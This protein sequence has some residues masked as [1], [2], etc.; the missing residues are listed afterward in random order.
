MTY[1]W[2]Y[3]MDVVGTPTMK[4]SKNYT[5]RDSEKRQSIF[6]LLLTLLIICLFKIIRTKLLKND[7]D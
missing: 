1:D 5:L 3:Y 6:K 2:K 7:T 4:W